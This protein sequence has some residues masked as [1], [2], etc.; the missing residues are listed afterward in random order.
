MNI[1][2]NTKD[3]YPVQI[4][5]SKPN[6]YLKWS[7][8]N[9]GTISLKLL[10]DECPC[11][12]CKG[13][14]ILLQEYKPVK[15]LN[16]RPGMYEL[17]NIQQVGNYAIQLFWGDGHSTGIY[18]WEKLRSLCETESPSSQPQKSTQ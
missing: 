18:T 5:L 11:A 9:E 1:N 13:E 6:L 12:S 17:K 4:K 15:E 10:R 2:M 7:D 3:L 14:T 8:G 16:E